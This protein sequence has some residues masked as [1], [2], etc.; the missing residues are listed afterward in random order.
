MLFLFQIQILIGKW[1]VVAYKNYLQPE[2][3]LERLVEHLHGH[4]PDDGLAHLVLG[5]DVH[6]AGV[7]G[8]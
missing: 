8:A 6:C 5:D 7:E 1:T 2:R 3:C 4:L